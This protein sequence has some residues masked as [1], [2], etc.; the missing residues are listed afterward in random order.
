MLVIEKCL[1]MRLILHGLSFT[2]D[3][4]PK[5][6]L[7]QAESVDEIWLDNYRHVKNSVSEMIFVRSKDYRLNL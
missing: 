7:S 4:P 2:V 6:N 3:S 1:F 5:K